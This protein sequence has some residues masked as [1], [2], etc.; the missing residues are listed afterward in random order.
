M[1]G[2]TL[3]HVLR[4]QNISLYAF[5]SSNAV[6]VKKKGRG[7]FAILRPF[8]VG[9]CFD[10]YTA[11]SQIALRGAFLRSVLLFAVFKCVFTALKNQ[12]IKGNIVFCGDLVQLLKKR[13][14]KADG[15]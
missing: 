8:L 12:K 1:C 15:A 14:G 10:F 7:I 3:F 13:L 2:S 4:K 9:R 5:V 11:L 6:L